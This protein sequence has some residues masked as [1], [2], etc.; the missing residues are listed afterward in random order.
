MAKIISTAD[1]RIG[2]GA[3]R[4]GWRDMLQQGWQ[5]YARWRQRQKLAE[6]DDRLLADL[7]LTRSDV[8]TEMP[9]A[10]WRRL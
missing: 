3:A 1:Q 9:E 2:A 7:G 5:I 6:L 8:R 4:S 10:P